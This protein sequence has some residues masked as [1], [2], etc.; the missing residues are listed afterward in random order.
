MEHNHG[1]F[2]DQTQAPLEA[3]LPRLNIVFFCESKELYDVAGQSVTDRRL[4]RSKISVYSGGISGAV[5]TYQDKPTPDLLVIESPQ[6]LNCLQNL[7]VL[8]R[9][10]TLIQKL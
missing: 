5:E 2:A 6:P 7:K 10:V 8:Q 4:K 1:S 3:Y 9:F